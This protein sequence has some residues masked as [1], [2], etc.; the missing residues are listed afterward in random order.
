MGDLVGGIFGGDQATP[1]YSGAIAA[2]E[3]KPYSISTGFGS[4]YWNKD[5]Q[6][7][8]YTLTP[9]LQKFRD[10]Y[11]KA[12]ESALP[13]ADQIQFAKD[14]TGYGQG[15]FSK[16]INLDTS[17]IAQ[18]Y[19]NKQLDILAPGRAAE[20]ARLADTLFTRG[21]TGAATGYGSGYLNPEQFALLSAREQA[22]AQLGLESTD[23]ARQQQL[24]DI[25]SA[26]G[27]YGLG[28]QL[29]TT[30]YNTASTL[31]GYGTNLESLGLTPLQ[32]GLSAG[33]AASSAGSNVAQLLAQQENARVAA[34]NDPGL[35]GSL[36]SGAVSAFAPALGGWA[37]GSLFGGATKGLSMASTLSGV[38]STA[39]RFLTRY[40]Q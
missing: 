5:A 3:F 40:G 21:R 15:L 14:V 39:N 1:D 36:V 2:A 35:F 33:Q 27:Y 19:Y 38:N 18:D 20:E 24:Q 7:G 30:P 11:Y 32:A 10:I 34:E 16:A 13:S 22:N 17:K 37:A 8:G 23:R 26:L 29:K 9:E 6:T 25:Q 31:F 28:E 4:S 12:A